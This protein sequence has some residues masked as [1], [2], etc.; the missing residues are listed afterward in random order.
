MGTYET[1]L[2]N[3]MSPFNDVLT[4]ISEKKEKALRQAF[5]NT[6]AII[7]VTFVLAFVVAVYFVL[8]PFLQPLIW[9]FLFGSALHPFKRK[10]THFVR[11][12][13]TNQ[14]KKPFTLFAM[15]L[16][17]TV[18]NYIINSTAKVVIQYYKLLLFIF[19]ALFLTHLGSFYF[20]ITHKLINFFSILINVGFKLFFTFLNICNIYISLT[21]LVVQL[22]LHCFF[23]SQINKRISSS[24]VS[25]LL[26]SL[27][28]IK[29]L[30][31]FGT[32]GLIIFC[33]LLIITLSGLIA[34]LIGRKDKSQD[35]KNSVQL[36]SFK[37]YQ[38][39]SLFCNSF[40]SILLS[41]PS[42]ETEKES[43]ENDEE[44]SG[45]IVTSKG[46]ICDVTPVSSLKASSLSYKPN[47]V[48]KIKKKENHLSNSYFYALLWSCLLAQVWL[49][50]SL[51]YLIL[52]PIAVF[53][54][55]WVG[56]QINQ[57]AYVSN[58]LNRAT[59]NIY[60]QLSSLVHPIFFTFY[61]YF[62][63]GDELVSFC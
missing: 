25:S 4:I 59:K 41:H 42:N 9:S 43:I 39:L 44:L 5:Y 23:S 17:F 57:Y 53:F 6:I 55:K 51:L 30:L 45:S 14:T 3:F 28:I 54:I 18:F 46:D 36:I 62:C 47:P 31:S 32:L 63:I 2:K 24:I 19:V 15:V 48:K 21:L 61:K 40:L 10:L 35:D 38:S 22:I 37:F 13:L 60:L 33:L 11:V 20:T 58:I 50:P 27:I 8:E 29:L 34:T 12:W 26:F 52:L 49:R 7:F 56:S 16:P 1:N